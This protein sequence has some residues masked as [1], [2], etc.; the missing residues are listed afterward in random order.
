[1]SKEL[2]AKQRSALQ[3]V[4]D[5]PELQPWLFK[6]VS[7]PVWFDA[8]ME[9][10]LLSPELN[11]KPIETK[12]N[13]F[14]I[15]SWPITEYLVG[16]SL[17]IKEE[18][19]RETA[20]K[21]L[22]LIRKVTHYAIDTDFGNH[23]TWWQFSKIL[24]NLPI[25]IISLDDMKYISFWL[26]DKFDTHLVGKE[27]SEWISELTDQTDVHS[28]DI[29]LA[30]L[31]VLFTVTSIDSRNFDHR[32]EAI[33]HFDSYQANE[34]VSKTAK[35]FGE[36]IGLPA[37][38]LF[39]SKLTNVLETNGNDKWSNLWRN[40]I[41]D[42]KQNSRHN[43][44]D[45][46]VLKLFR[47]AMLG[48]YQ[49]NR[50]EE[51]E[52]KLVNLLNSEYET[53]KRI[54]VYIATE[55]FE[56][57]EDST[58]EQVIA[59]ANFNDKFRH[60]FWHFL[61]KN[62]AKLTVPY[63]ASV[64]ESI[65]SLEVKNEAD[66]TE[67]KPTAYKQANWYAAIIEI[68]EIAR[69]NYQKCVKIVGVEP[70]HPDY[71]CHT[72][73]GSVVNKSALSVTELAQMLEE[74][75]KLVQY[76]NNYEHI[77]HF[78]E[79]SIEGL[80]E[81][82]GSLVSLDDCIILNNLEQFINLKPHYLHEIYSSYSKLWTLRKQ[83]D[84]SSLWPKL[85]EF[86]D[87]LFQLEVFWQ[88][89]TNKESGPF[90]GDVHWVVS[91][92]CRLIESGCEKNEY[93]FDLNLC[94]PA[95]KT[96]EQILFR[97][98]GSDF[99]NESDAVS[100]A[101]NSPRGRCLEAYFKLALYQCRNVTNGP[102]QHAEI[103]STYEPVFSN[104]LNKPTTFNEYEFITLVVMYIQ[105]FQFLSKDWTHANL[106]IMFGEINSQQ[107]L[108]AIQAY[109]YVGR[110][111]PEVHNIFKGK[112]YYLLLLDSPCLNDSVKGRFVEYICIAYLQDLEKLADDNGLL[113]SLLDRENDKELSKLIWFL[114]SLRDKNNDTTTEI[115]FW[116]WPKLIELI[117]KQTSEQ[118]PIA[119]KLS[120]WTEYIEQ[121]D[122]QSKSWLLEIAPFINDDH[123]GDSFLKELARLSNTNALNAADIWKATLINP[124]YIYDFEPIEQMFKNLI[125]LGK[126]GKETA[127]E[128]ADMYIK[129]KDEAVVELYQRVIKGYAISG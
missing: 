116:L 10:G 52:V 95:K 26:A 126:E 78:G 92:Y 90:I 2:S 71:S 49:T 44:V 64:I 97:E 129:H 110:L 103:W 81:T 117:K 11:P 33:L 122:D 128:I 99:D 47:D 34:F 104:E 72:S 12:E 7:D 31:D 74:P 13:K 66:A 54:A 6:K 48:Y 67:N 42:H 106:E 32:K 28:I 17:K 5:D 14:H 94:E 108:C 59:K 69:S 63:K 76:L 80:V 79:E 51:S 15:P 43:D 114:W 61:N 3:R 22:S 112:N 16:S 120:L 18:N 29:T 58:I 124:F 84:W 4:I 20:E 113:S 85:I 109:S 119:S 53:I 107:W 77:G 82:F 1:M 8:F 118:K 83:R 40:A 55:C 101:I 35:R 60:E 23:R 68:D 24:R 36:Q 41:E 127:T 86:S 93:A 56:H 75:N 96:L 125:A 70:D 39:E 98:S 25:N 123:N 27:I 89:P 62:F 88:T 46:I 57:L 30:L 38:E 19:D 21:Y 9:Q 121:L 73:V 65:S 37:I 100:V 91:A 87:D 50:K 115:V 102:G 105:N 45:D 111:L